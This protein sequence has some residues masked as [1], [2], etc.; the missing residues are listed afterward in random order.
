MSDASVKLRVDVSGFERSL[1]RLTELAEH[2]P[3]L[4]DCLID[5]PHLR[6]KLFRIVPSYGAAPGTRDLRVRFEASD[7]LLK[8]VTAL[9]ALEGEGFVPEELR[10]V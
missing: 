1:S 5:A 6:A 3:E 10:H 9:E 7:F 8:L 4:V 2:A